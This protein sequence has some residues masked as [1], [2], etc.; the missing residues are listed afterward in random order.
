MATA[1]HQTAQGKQA[2]VEVQEEVGDFG[3][4][5]SLLGH[6]DFKLVAWWQREQVIAVGHLE[7][8]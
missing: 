1:N 2:Q 3:D 4:A 8:A 6:P 7:Y 5:N